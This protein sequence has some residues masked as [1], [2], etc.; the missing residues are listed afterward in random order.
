MSETVGEPRPEG[1]PA[2]LRGIITGRADPR[3][4]ATW[5]V[6]LAA[7]LI[8]LTEVVARAGAAALGTTGLV[9]TGLL[10]AGAF[11]LLL[12]AWA[13]YVDRRNLTAYGLSVSGAWL[14]DLAVALGAVVAAHGAWYALGTSLGWTSVEVAASAPGGSLALGLAAAFVAVAVNVWVQATVYFGLVL[15]SAAEGLRSRGLEPRRAVGGGWVVGVLFVVWVHG[16]GLD[17]ALGLTAAGALFGL[18]YV[19][20]GELALPIGFHL[21]V[22]FSGGS[23]FVSAAAAGE[24]TAVFAVAETLPALG[25]LSEPRI[26]QMLLAYLLVVAWLR[27]R[28]GAVG[29]EAGVA[30]WDG[31]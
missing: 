2:R 27:W 18:L 9:S 13:R 26:P 12:V 17:R 29:V 20:T 31:R 5:R 11:G 6:L 19:H 22:N 23:L 24:R 16:G 30:R 25:A 4:R 14:L 15:R 10:Q 8:L 1:I 21:G 3:L 7:P 28:R